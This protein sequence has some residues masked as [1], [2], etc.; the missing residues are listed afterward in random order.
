ML[1]FRVSDR[2]GAPEEKKMFCWSRGG[3]HVLERERRQGPKKADRC[4][5]FRQQKAS[6][7]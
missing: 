7:A 5:L 3:F 4:H 1:F 6:V 2:L